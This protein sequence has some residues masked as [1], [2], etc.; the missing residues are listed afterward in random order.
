MKFGKAVPEKDKSP[1][2]D[3]GLLDIDILDSLRIRL[4][5]IKKNS[6]VSKGNQGSSCPPSDQDESMWLF[7]YHLN[8]DLSANYHPLC[9]PQT[10]L[11][12]Y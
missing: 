10:G 4:H 11:W 3:F 7:S 12:A 9:K 8:S 6:L 1:E 5:V 2:I